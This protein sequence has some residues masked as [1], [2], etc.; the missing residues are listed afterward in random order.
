MSVVETD[1]ASWTWARSSAS[2]CSTD[3]MRLKL[4]P[5][6]LEEPSH[7]LRGI[8]RF[9]QRQDLLFQ[10]TANKLDVACFC[11]VVDYLGFLEFG[12]MGMVKSDPNTPSVFVGLP[13]WVFISNLVCNVIYERIVFQSL[14]R[15]AV[16][17]VEDSSSMFVRYCRQNRVRGNRSFTPR[18]IGLLVN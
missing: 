15:R 4:E 12:E 13:F 18:R 8:V 1:V 6:T 5:I 9:D 7:S 17:C 16:Q 3:R 10:F 11:L 2:N 14:R